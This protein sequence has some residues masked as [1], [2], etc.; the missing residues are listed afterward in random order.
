MNKNNN[1][2]KNHIYRALGKPPY[3]VYN[4]NAPTLE[5]IKKLVNEGRH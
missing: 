3:E 4:G 5:N 1:K 2:N